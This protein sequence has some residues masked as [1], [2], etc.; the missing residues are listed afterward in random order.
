MH[1]TTT[2]V[3]LGQLEAA[4]DH[5]EGLG[6]GDGGK[7]AL[8]AMS[9]RAA[10]LERE[11]GTCRE[12]LTR[13]A[14]ENDELRDEKRTLKRTHKEE[15]ETL[16]RAMETLQGRE[17]VLRGGQCTWAQT[18]A[19]AMFIVTSP[20]KKSA[21]VFRMQERLEMFVERQS[22]K[23]HASCGVRVYCVGRCGSVT[24]ML[25]GCDVEDSDKL[26][27]FAW[28]ELTDRGEGVQSVIV[29]EDIA[30]AEERRRAKR[31]L[32][33]AAAARAAG[34]SGGVPACDRGRALYD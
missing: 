21:W 1:G 2:G 26:L 22:K 28:Q 23:D 33:Q 18:H 8:A 32:A 30:L 14:R 15:M 17:R 7:A 16:R 29:L 13:A 19:V 5:T 11:L 6:W 9:A 34:G 12:T 4:L 20:D 25:G 10:A 3:L 24:A 31:R 27:T